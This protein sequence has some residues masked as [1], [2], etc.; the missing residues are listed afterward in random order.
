VR[1][2]VRGHDHVPDRWQLFPEYAEYPV[3]TINA[4]GRWLDGEM[5]TAAGHPLPV[6]ARHAP[7]HLPEV[8]RLP[9][10]PA[11]VARAFP[12]W[13]DPV[14]AAGEDD[15]VIGGP[16]VNGPSPDPGPGGGR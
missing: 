13:N 16:P 11:E 6:V 4:M 12:R 7:G 9:L 5:P 2:L 10:D 8:V 1:R 3:L 15:M 14:P